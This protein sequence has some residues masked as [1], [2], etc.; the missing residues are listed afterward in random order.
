MAPFKFKG[1]ILRNLGCGGV[2]AAGK[3]SESFLTKILQV[4]ADVIFTYENLI[5][6]ITAQN[7]YIH[8]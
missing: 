3:E 6:W 5:P 7:K 2:M 4:V 1:L 8:V